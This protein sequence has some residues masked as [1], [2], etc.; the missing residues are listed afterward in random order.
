MVQTAREFI[1]AQQ[2]VHPP[3]RPTAEQAQAVADS[4]G[5]HQADAV[6][7]ERDYA[8]K[9]LGLLQPGLPPVIVELMRNG[10]IAV[11]EVGHDSANAYLTPLN[12]D[13][14]IVL[15]S[16]LP[17]FVYRIARPLVTA[18]RT[19]ASD[20]SG[21]IPT[22][23][24]ARII[25]EVFWWY[26]ETG[27]AFG[28]AYSTT[29]QD[30]VLA[31]AVATY[32]EAFLVGHEIGHV[33][34]SQSDTWR[35]GCAPDDLVLREEYVADTAGVLTLLKAVQAGRGPH[36]RDLQVAYAGAELALQIWQLMA[37]VGMT[38]VDGTHPPSARRIDNLR[39]VVRDHCASED[40]FLA[41]TALARGVQDVLTEVA[42]ILL[43]PKEHEAAYERAASEVSGAVLNLVEHCTG[44]MVPDYST[45]YEQF[46]RVLSR[47]Y[48]AVI[49]ERVVVKIA[50][51]MKAAQDA[52]PKK[53]DWKTP[54]EWTEAEQAVI[55]RW[56]L[57]FQG[58]KLFYGMS[59]FLGGPV[60]Q[61]FMNALERELRDGATPS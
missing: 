30:I 11:G 35:Q 54:P 17:Q 58:F 22:S 53:A 6:A 32:A 24:L 33:F 42:R 19:Q 49:V 52:L 34:A 13:F 21:S 51:E 26:Q 20:A 31:S 8:E 48:P 55:R 61:L 56:G 1:E 15:H 28:P 14:A 44:G 47:G 43:D 29:S 10:R 18:L 9:L 7:S 3:R 25:A 4:Y 36:P 37:T 12:G 16:G 57:R 39:G 41:L 27:I 46:P 59:E 40:D 23:E 5:L 38:F 60:A 2:A 50:R 45:F